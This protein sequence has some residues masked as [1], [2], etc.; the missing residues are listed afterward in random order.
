MTGSV[1]SAL[2]H[3]L[4]EFEGETYPFHIGDTWMEPAVGTRMEDLNVGDHPG[5]HRYAP[6][7]GRRDLLEAIAERTL[8]RTGEPTEPAD[9][10]VTVL[11][12]LN[13]FAKQD[14]QTNLN[15]AVIAATSGAPLGWIFPS[16]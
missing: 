3:Q 11:E 7:Q 10:L 15:C 4:R 12:A 8:A 5:M 14:S 1:Y 16:W 13:P 2:V 9:I 6:V